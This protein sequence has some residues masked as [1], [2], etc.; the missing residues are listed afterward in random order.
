[1]ALP[2]FRYLPNFDYVSRL[3][4]SKYIGDYVQVKNL[5]RRAKIN[6]EL[7]QNINF[8]T[9]YQIVGNE[10]PDNVAYRLYNNPYLD[11]LV[12]LANNIINVEEEWPL[13][14]QSFFN[15]MLSKYGSETAF[16][17]PH[18]YETSEIKDSNG[19]VIMRKGLEVASDYSI[20]YFDSGT[21]QLVTNNNVSIVVTNYDYEDKIQDSKRNIF[22]VKGQYLSQIL[23]DLEDGLLYKSGSSQYISDKNAK[24]DNIRL[25]E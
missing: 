14:Q 1:M 6:P 7:F 22:V 20:T 16:N 13:T 3:P 17:E 2:Y 11:W 8:F 23:N 10:R 12:L 19:K 9:K 24:A 21:N 15:Y 18:H 4:D 25:Y 5:F